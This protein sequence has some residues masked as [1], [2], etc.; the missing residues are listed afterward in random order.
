MRMCVSAATAVM[1]SVA[2]AVPCAHPGGQ[3]EQTVFVREKAGCCWQDGLLIGDG[4]TGA[5]GYAPAGLEWTINRND[6]LDSRV[7]TCD[8]VPHEEVMRC[9]ATNR[10]HSVSFLGALESPRIRKYPDMGDQLTLSL[11][12]AQLKVRFW[13]GLGWAM[14]SVPST[15]QALD[16]RTGELVESLHSPK[17]ALSAVSFV[18]RSRDVMVVSLEDVADPSR[19]AHVELSRPEDV[20]TDSLPFAW[21]EA[22]GVI[23][24]SQRLPGGETCAVAMSAPSK[25]KVLGRTASVQMRCGGSA[26]FL[27]VRTTCDAADPVMAAIAAVQDAVNDGLAALRA[28]NR[29][30]WGNFWREGARARFGSDPA[31]EREWNYAVYALASQ[32]GGAPMPALNGL[33]YGPLDGAHGGV[34]SNCYVHDQNV[35]IPMMPFFPLGHAKFVTAFVKTYMN[36]MGEL[37]R[38]TKE[39]FGAEGAYLPLNMN[40]FCR[41]HP[42]AEYRYTLC[43]G[44]YSGLVLAQAW[45]YTHDETILEEIYPLL[46]KLIL[47][48]TSTMT[49]DEKGTYHFLWSVPP[50]IFTGTKDELAT[51]ACLKPCLETAVEAASRFKCDDRELALWKDILAHYPKFARQSTGCWWGG[52]EIPDDHYMYGGHLFYPFFP[53]EADA[54]VETAKRTLDYHRDYAVEVSYETEEPHPVHE[55]SALYS[56]IAKVRIFGGDRGW[57]TVRDFY[58]WFSKPNGLFSHNPIILTRLTREDVRAN[59]AKAPKLVRRDCNGDVGERGRGGP[60]D[61]AYSVDCKAFVAPVL[62][63]AAAFL[64][65]SS[66]A[67]CQ[68]WG[69]EIRIFPS[70]QADFTGSFENFRVHGGYVVSAKMDKGRVIDFSLKGMKPGDRV[71]VRCPM[72]PDFVAQPCPSSGACGSLKMKGAGESCLWTFDVSSDAPVVR[73]GAEKLRDFLERKCPSGCDEG[74]RRVVIA[75]APERDPLTSRIAVT[76]GEVRVTGATPRETLQGCYR[77]MDELEAGERPVFRKG[78]RTY[79]R[80]FSP[81]MVHSGYEIEKYTDEHMDEIARAGLDAILVYVNNPPDGTRNGRADFPALVKRA[82]VHGLDVY[83]YADF[84]WNPLLMNPCDPGAE[85]NYDEVFGSIAKN[86]PGLKGIVCVGESCYFP[87]RGNLPPKFGAGRPDRSNSCKPTLD[88]AE[89]LRLVTKVTRKYSPGFD[90]VFWT[91]NWCGKPEAD[92]V[93]LLEA[94]PTNVTVHV[95]FEMG[96]PA[97]VKDGVEFH[98]DD[99]SITEPGPGTTFVSEAEVCARRGIPLTAMSNTGGRTWDFGGMPFEPVPYVWMERFRR[100]RAARSRWGLKGLMDSHH[101]GFVPNFIADLAKVAFTCE[102]GDREITEALRAL[103][104]REFGSSCA[105]EGLATWKEWSEA[106][107]WHSARAYDQYGP[108]RLGSTYPLLRPDEPFPPSPRPV[109]EFVNGRRNG[110][111]WLYLNPRYRCPDDV[112]EGR[113]RTDARELALLESGNARLASLLGKVPADKVASVKRMLGYGRYMAA[114]VRTLW[115]VRRYRLA[116]LAKDDAERHRILDDEDSNVR[117]LIPWVEND[118]RLGFE[119]SMR[120][121]TDSFMLK[122]KLGLLSAARGGK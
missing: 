55:W 45:W 93:A 50:E 61:L 32:F 11:S 44:A 53:S 49:R 77:L 2:I 33:A 103:A 52:P 70:V 113:I 67:L 117:S 48:Y 56:G 89:F 16:T 78:T 96:A 17:M 43:G 37:E 111:G 105:D 74:V 18:E 62:E 8:Y 108:L 1:A 83:A 9:V 119:P 101:Y 121:V 116:C 23:A 59:L 69:G 20:R 39:A 80:M 110:N 112:C 63:G 42:V 86:A 28:A 106:F 97:Y 54:D 87:K 31:V 12:A 81:R 98:V 36:G 19:I 26:V 40:Q 92:R 64:L 95:T 84:Y 91:Y 22:D 82:A 47:F 5:L 10:G 15:R 30:W 104:V 71:N 122:W 21:R 46:K 38:R 34:A 76:D 25:A 99:Y 100:L 115:N 114:A 27:A 65:L 85:E 66:E 102:L 107:E 60:D 3:E 120:Y 88:W 58:E 73:H 118:S 35:Q 57:R 109:Y 90:V 6:V 51:I 79:T 72:D 29:T 75:V 94:I 41:E 24:F 14:P 7:C 4:R 68:S 13:G